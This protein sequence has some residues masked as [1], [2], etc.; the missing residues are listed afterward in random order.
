MKRTISNA[1]EP[2]PKHF[3]STAAI[4]ASLENTDRILVSG[5]N[6]DPIALGPGQRLIVRGDLSRI[7]VSGPN[8]SYSVEAV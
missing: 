2:L 3:R 8:Q 4:V 1:I 7:E 6:L 5:N